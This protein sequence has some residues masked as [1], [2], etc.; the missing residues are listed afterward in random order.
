LISGFP[1]GGPNDIVARLVG[2][3]LWERLGQAFVVENRPGA[4]SNIVT[5]AVV[6]AAPDGYTLLL[7]NSPNAINATL[8]DNLNFRVSARHRAGRQHR[9]H[10]PHHGAASV[11]STCLN[12]ATE[13]LRTFQNRKQSPR[14]TVSTAANLL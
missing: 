13:Y 3:L 6:R 9:P 2:Q 14:S 8:H 11:G 4:S 12:Q 1:A 5:G 7:I 10:D